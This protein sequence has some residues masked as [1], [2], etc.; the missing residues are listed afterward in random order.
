V[1]SHNPPQ[2]PTTC[3]TAL[4]PAGTF[5]AAYACNRDEAVDG[6]IEADP[7]GF[8]IRSMM[9]TRTEWTGTA[10]GLL[11]ALDEEAEE[12]ARTRRRSHPI[13]GLHKS[14]P[15]EDSLWVLERQTVKV[16]TLLN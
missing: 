10:S 2:C 8:A 1:L 16:P 7:I 3:E 14:S 5:G 11:G 15:L 13:P 12:K 4:W 9:N 6:M